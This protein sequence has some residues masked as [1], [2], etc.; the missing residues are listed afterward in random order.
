MLVPNKIVCDKV[1]DRLW[2]VGVR[3]GDLGKLENEVSR[4]DDVRRCQENRVSVCC[5]LCVADVG[6]DFLKNWE[7]DR[8][9]TSMVLK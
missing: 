5:K 4:Y 7:H 6:V 8:S 9:A 2:H 3:V 1:C